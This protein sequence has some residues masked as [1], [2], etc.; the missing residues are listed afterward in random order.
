MQ[1]DQAL[2][3]LHREKSKTSHLEKEIRDLEYQQSNLKAQSDSR[4]HQLE[5]EI[6]QLRSSLDEDSVKRQEMAQISEQRIQS[7]DRDLAEMRAELQREK[8]LRIQA[9]RENE[10]IK[11]DNYFMQQKTSQDVQS[12]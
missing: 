12:L 8:E 10:E 7:L 11:R 5:R 2:D 3:D 6:A 9:E 1:R 4:T